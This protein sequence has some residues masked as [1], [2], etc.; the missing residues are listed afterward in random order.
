MKRFPFLSKWWKEDK[1]DIMAYVYW[2][3]DQLPPSD[4]E[5]YEKNWENIKRQLTKKYG[6]GT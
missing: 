2:M 5:K 1:K 4:P 6:D 3:Q